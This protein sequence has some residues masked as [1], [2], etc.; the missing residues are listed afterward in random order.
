L[1]KGKFPSSSGAAYFAPDGA[2]AALDLKLQ[3][4]RAYGAGKHDTNLKIYPLAA[5]RSGVARH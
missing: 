3:I 1:S 5:V 2:C 4:C